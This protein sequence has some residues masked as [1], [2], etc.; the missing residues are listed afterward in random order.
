MYHSAKFN[1]LKVNG[2]GVFDR[3]FTKSLIKSDFDD[4]LKNPFRYVDL[5]LL[6]ALLSKKISKIAM[7][8][9]QQRVQSCGA[10]PLPPLPLNE[11]LALINPVF[12]PTSSTNVLLTIV[13]KNCKLQHLEGTF[14]KTSYLSVFGLCRPIIYRP[15]EL[16]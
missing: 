14:L 5:Y 3:E 16:F 11:G 2:G 15:D 12:C 9:L 7:Q 10:T 1:G 6:H 4:V 13:Q 8:D